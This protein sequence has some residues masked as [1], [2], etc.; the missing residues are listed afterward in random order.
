MKRPNF[1]IVGAPKCGTTAMA[2]FLG[3]HPEIYMAWQKEACFFGSDLHRK[4]QID[5]ETLFDLY[6]ALFNNAADEKVIGEASVMYLISKKSAEEIKAF[7]PNAKILIMLRNPVDMQYSH[8]SQLLYN[9]DEDISDFKAA[10]EAE[11]ARMHGERIPVD[12]SM[13]DF[14]YYRNMAT[15]YPQVQRYFDAFGKE[16]VHVIIFDDFKANNAAVYKRTL[17][18][19]NVRDDFLP[20]FSIINPNKVNKSNT[21]HRFVK[22]PPSIVKK[23]K[24]LIPWK[25]RVKTRY[26]LYQLNQKKGARPSLDEKLRKELIKDFIPD[27]DKLSALLERDLSFWY[28]DK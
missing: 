21:F 26:K 5:K 8:H 20:D 11:P 13:T 2:D 24:H 22:Y 7:A 9:L 28:T 6:L 4:L 12:T 1:F 16:N 10:L 18:F 23:I 17:Q 3:L 27:I 15:Y 14:L 25:L 19:L